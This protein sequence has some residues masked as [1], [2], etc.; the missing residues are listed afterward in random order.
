MT[1]LSAPD[2]RFTV[3]SDRQKIFLTI[4]LSLA[5]LASPLAATSYV[6]LLPLLSRLF[7][8]SLEA[9]N[10]SVT[11]YVIFQAISP[12]LFAPYADV[13]G[14]RPVFFI[15]YC[16][17][18]L[19][20]LG[21]ALNGTKSYAGLLVL[22]A[23]QSLGASAVLSLSYGVVA[24]VAIPSERGKMLGP[25]GAIG[26][27]GVC[28]GPIVGGS[29]AFGSGNVKWVFWSLVIFGGAM[30]LAT[31]LV[32]PE[33]GRNIVGN[34][35]TPPTGCYRTWWRALFSQEGG[36]DDEA[37]RSASNNVFVVEAPRDKAIQHRWTVLLPKNPFFGIRIIFYKDAALVLFLSSIFY[38]TYYCIQASISV[39]FEST[40]SF[41][42]LQVGLAYLP[43]GLGCIIGATFTG[44][45]MDHN[46]RVT[47]N[48]M[49]HEVD[50]IKGDNMMDFPI[51]R[52][53]TRFCLHFL[54]LYTAAFVGYGWAA[55]THTHFSVCLILQAVL[56]L[57]CMLFNIV[58]QALLIDIFPANS[59]AAAATGNLARCCLT[60]ILISVLQPGLDKMGRGWYFT[61]L[62]LLSGLGGIVIVLLI[63]SRGLQWRT[64][65]TKG[66]QDAK[67]PDSP[68]GSN[69]NVLDI[70]HS[71]DEIK[72]SQSQDVCDAEK[73]S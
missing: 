9:I 60:A 71:L 17:F 41:N 50:K 67:S 52:V 20:S 45:F 70:K 18:T 36:N 3:F 40:Y 42:A 59:S 72:H 21:L 53:R 68:R 61:L 38:A 54:V 6:P 15:T 48:K 51:E 47:A 29:I 63:R 73:A 19:A 7:S 58:S 10:L 56:G 25:I 69:T 37:I 49:G 26:N 14:R 16:L 65:R 32:F 30:T 28:I 5:N 33:T 55:E 4:I 1:N 2:E 8:T 66:S 57:F 39:I 34:G 13:H 12:S 44:S 22:R 11:V 62:G 24:D 46:Y 35:S 31:G 27:L 43:G 23:L 64:E